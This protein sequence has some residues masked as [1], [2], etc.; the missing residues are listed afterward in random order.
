[1]TDKVAETLLRLPLHP[2]LAEEDVDR[3]IAGV[4]EASA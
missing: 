1:V 2:L 3:V 4:R